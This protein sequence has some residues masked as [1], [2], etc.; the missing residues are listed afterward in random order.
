ML[1]KAC[2]GKSPLILG[3][4]QIRVRLSGALMHKAPIFY[5]RQPGLYTENSLSPAMLM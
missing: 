2:S 3:P 5:T 4:M 1:S